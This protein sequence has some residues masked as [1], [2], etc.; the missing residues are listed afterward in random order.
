VKINPLEHGNLPDSEATIIRSLVDRIESLEQQLRELK[1]NQI[2]ENC[3]LSE[4]SV[5]S[6][7]FKKAEIPKFM[8][9]AGI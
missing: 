2:L 3:Y 4:A 9:G 6:T 7:S 1:T 5:D 8:D